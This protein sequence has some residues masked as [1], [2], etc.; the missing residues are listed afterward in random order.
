MRMNFCSMAYACMFSHLVDIAAERFYMLLRVN[1]NEMSFNGGA[2]ADVVHNHNSKFSGIFRVK[3]HAPSTSEQRRIWGTNLRQIIHNFL[4]PHAQN[5][6]RQWRISSQGF[7][8]GCSQW[9][10]DYWICRPIDIFYSKYL[11][12]EERGSFGC[13]H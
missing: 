6:T 2:A 3:L 7:D 12:E 9:L 4:T 13:L 5:G 11:D 1:M 8:Q 10:D